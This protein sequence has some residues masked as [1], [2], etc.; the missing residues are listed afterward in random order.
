MEE[1]FSNFLHEFERIY[2]VLSTEQDTFLRSVTVLQELLK[3]QQQVLFE[4]EDFEEHD[5]ARSIDIH[6]TKSVDESEMQLAMGTTHSLLGTVFSQLENYTSALYHH[7]QATFIR[8]KFLGKFHFRSALSVCDIGE[9]LIRMGRYHAA[10]ELIAEARVILESASTEPEVISNLP[11]IISNHAAALVGCG[12]Y[13]EAINCGQKALSF[14]EEVKGIDHIDSVAPMLSMARAYMQLRDIDSAETHATAAIE[15]VERI[16]SRS[17]IPLAPPEAAYPPPPPHSHLM[18]SSSKALRSSVTRLQ[19]PGS[20]TSS[21]SILRPVTKNKTLSRGVVNA[22]SSGSLHTLRAYSSSHVGPS[23]PAPRGHLGHSVGEMSSSNFFRPKTPTV[24]HSSVSAQSYIPQSSHTP[25][26]LTFCDCCAVLCEVYG[27]NINIV[28]GRNIQHVTG[29]KSHDVF[30]KKALRK[31]EEEEGERARL[32]EALGYI[33]KAKRVLI[34]QLGLSPSHRRVLNLDEIVIIYLIQLDRCDECIEI[35]Q[36]LVRCRKQTYDGEGGERLFKRLEKLQSQGNLSAKKRPR[37]AS[38]GPKVKGSRH[39]SSSP[40]VSTASLS[41]SASAS[42]HGIS[43]SRQNLLGSRP[44][45]H[46]SASSKRHLIPPRP[47]SSASLAASSSSSSLYSAS[48]RGKTGISHGTGVEGES[49]VPPGFCDACISFANALSLYASIER[50]LK[51]YKQALTLAKKAITMA[52]A[53]LTPFSMNSALLRINASGVLLDICQAH[54]DPRPK[55]RK[56]YLELKREKEFKTAPGA[57]VSSLPNS[58]HFESLSDISQPMKVSMCEKAVKMLQHSLNVL[59]AVSGST[60]SDSEKEST[61]A[62]GRLVSARIISC[63][64]SVSSINVVRCQIG[65]ASAFLM[66]GVLV[67]SLSPSYSFSSITHSQQCGSKAL[68]LLKE[69]KKSVESTYG[70]EHPICRSVGRKIA[71]LLRQRIILGRKE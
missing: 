50:C 18:S 17:G 10:E 13:Q 30:T 60:E 48:G 65:L 25:V 28:E 29:G 24:P 44:R 62:S 4:L 37:S 38:A 41:V 63:C 40:A 8:V 5:S 42:T 26:F 51:N 2:G 16:A 12:Q 35:I 68:V 69:A 56:S 54:S 67:S 32:E 58:T 11:G 70:S 47:S 27:M 31:I 46:P 59:E 53:I 71:L 22:A 43:S 1:Y 36:H 33:L 57:S 14:V 7:E 20:S 9:I 49:I 15:T 55:E 19:A 45:L 21:S 39:L 64:D 3:Y 66:L 52:D 23:S 34:S 6:K 61:I